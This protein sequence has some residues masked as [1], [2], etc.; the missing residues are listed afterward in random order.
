[1]L[2]HWIV[3]GVSVD[4]SGAPLASL[5]TNRYRAILPA[6]GLGERG[7]RVKL[8]PMETWVAPDFDRLGKGQPDIV[9]VG[10]LLPRLQGDAGR[11]ERLGTSVI[12]SV[13]KA[14]ASGA[15]VFAD[16]NDDHFTDQKRGGYFRALV[17]AVDGVVAGS[18][19]MAQ[20]V[21]RH[22]DRPL[23]VVGDPLGAPLGGPSVFRRRENWAVRLLSLVLPKQLVRQRLRLVWYGNAP[24][25]PSMAAWADRLVGL[26]KEQPL[27]IR[28][29]TREDAGVEEFARKFNVRHA[30]AA[31]MEFIPWQEDTVWGIVA[32]S[33]IVLIP[34]DLEDSRKSVKTANRLTDALHC[35]R[36]VVA[37]MV[38]AYAAY[39]DCAW[40]GENLV[41]GIR[42][43]I[44]R[45]DEALERVRRGQ[46]RVAERCSI[47]AIAASWEMAFLSLQPS[48]AAAGTVRV[49]GQPAQVRPANQSQGE[50]AAPV[51]LNLGCGD[52]L[53][54]G[55]VN[56]DV[57]PSRRGLRPDVL[58]D[59]H[60]LGVF[61]SDSADEI[62]AVHVVEHFWRW[63]VL[64]IL[65]EWVRVLKPGGKMV[66]ECPNLISAC[67][68]LLG[69]PENAS[70]G[71][72]RGQ[73]S[74]WVFYGDPAWQDPL[75]THRWAYTPNSL[76]SL[77]QEA[78]LAEVRQEP[79]Q[80]KLREPRDMRVVGI[81][82]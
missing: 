19:A 13:E 6:T 14:R 71:D 20:V 74:M 54:E 15:K 57:A 65:K 68:A 66:L 72:A 26:T 46:E 62:L 17:V 11:Y 59:L 35:G 8:I 1:M 23:F 38:P 69:D 3:D 12:A 63:E 70:Q 28:I 61:A 2:I 22:S 33:H 51:R 16:I 41:D 80:F 39:E 50:N 73:R 55:Y 79:A 82:P 52:K 75:M 56:V 48:V 31:L 78:G 43:A 18:P 10:K 58:C 30:P 7:H 5:A 9:V 81:K 77:M 27:L 36:F 32:E 25:W 53:L 29:V 4:A 47:E 34:S 21:G 40:L 49:E 37:S 60:D 76:A 64:D 24:N 45:P 67:Q 44:E 42:W